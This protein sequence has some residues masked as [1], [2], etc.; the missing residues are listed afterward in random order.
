MGLGMALF[1]FGGYG[2]DYL[3]GTSPWFLVAGVVLGGAALMYD[4]VRT[5]LRRREEGPWSGR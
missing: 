2:L 5:A 3:L 4:L 1:V